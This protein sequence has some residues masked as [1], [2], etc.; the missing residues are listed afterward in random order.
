MREPGRS[1]GRTKKELNREVRLGYPVYE[2]QKFCPTCERQKLGSF[3]GDIQITETDGGFLYT[4]FRCRNW[5]N[6]Q[7]TFH[8]W[9]SKEEIKPTRK[10]KN[11]L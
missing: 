1:G 5:D 8:V 4:L 11:E 7:E 10:K 6:P 3:E 2:H 9:W